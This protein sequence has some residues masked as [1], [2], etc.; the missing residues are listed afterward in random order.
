M[1]QF[2]P[3]V[4]DTD[5]LLNLSLPR[6]PCVTNRNELPCDEA[7]TLGKISRWG[8]CTAAECTVWGAGGVTPLHP[9]PSV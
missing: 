3:Q 6:S 7:G 4:S 9:A 2:G 8:G 5:F 1:W